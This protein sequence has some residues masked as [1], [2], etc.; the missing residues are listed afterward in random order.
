FAAWASSGGASSG[1]WYLQPSGDPTDHGFAIQDYVP[2]K[3]WTVE[4]P[5]G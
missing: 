5:G 1:G 4:L 2:V 3:A